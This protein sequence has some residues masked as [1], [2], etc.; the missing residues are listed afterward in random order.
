MAPPPPA[1]GGPRKLNPNSQSFSFLQPDQLECYPISSYHPTPTYPPPP[2]PSMF[3]PPP[4]PPPRGYYQGPWSSATSPAP[5]SSSSSPKP[6]YSPYYPTTPPP[7]PPPPPLRSASSNGGI[8]LPLS[9]NGPHHHHLPPPPPPP[10]SHSPI[11]SPYLAHPLVPRQPSPALQPTPSTSSATT[12]P[13]SRGG[14]AHTTIAHPPPPP[15]PPPAATLGLSHPLQSLAPSAS[16]S[17]SSPSTTPG[18]VRFSAQPSSLPVS[19]ATPLPPLATSNRMSSTEGDDVG[20][21]GSF[22][23]TQH[24]HARFHHG[25][26]GGGGSPATSG[27]EQTLAG[28]STGFG[29]GD[30]GSDKSGGTRYGTS[31]SSPGTTTQRPDVAPTFAASNAPPNSSRRPLDAVDSPAASSSHP[32]PRHPPPPRSSPSH[33]L[34]P[35]LPRQHSSTPA[36]HPVVA[37]PSTPARIRLEKLPPARLF[38]AITLSRKVVVPV[39]FKFP[40]GVTIGWGV[41]KVDKEEEEEEEDRDGETKESRKDAEKEGLGK[42]AVEEEKEEQAESNTAETTPRVDAVPTVRST[43]NT[44]SSAP[45]QGASASVPPPRSD[46][47]PASTSTPISTSTPGPAPAPA[48]APAPA[49]STTTRKPTST[50]PK[51]WADLVRPPPGSTPPASTKGGITP[52]SATLASAPPPP[53][54][55]SELADPASSSSSLSS[56]SP[57]LGSLSALP[58]H[59]HYPGPPVARG[60]INNGNL[61]FANAILQALVY[62]GAF[63]ETLR[64]VER[65]TRADLRTNG[66]KGRTATEAMIAFLAEFRHPSSNLASTAFH[67]SNP[68]PAASSSIPST[69]A[70]SS[71]SSTAVPSSSSS[72]SSS[73]MNPVAPLP[74]TSSSGSS[75]AAATPSTSTTP[76]STSRSHPHLA[77]SSS[78]S[79]LPY[80]SSFS[81]PSSASSSSSLPP[82]SPTPIHDALSSNPRFDAMRRGTQEDAE[83]FLGFFLETLSEEVGEM[84]RKEEE[85]VHK[86]RQGL[87][88]AASTS[89]SNAAAGAGGGPGGVGVNGKG[90]ERELG[91][92]SQDQDGEGWE[93]VGSKG[94]TAVTRTTGE[95]KESPIS[96][97]FGGRLRSVLRCPGQKDS[98]T[99]EPFQRL[100][101]DIQPDHVRTIEDALRNLTSPESLPDFMTSRGHPTSDATKQVTL[102]ELPPVLILHLKRF[103]YDE[104]GGVQKSTKRVG[105]GTQLRI[106]EKVVSPTRRVGVEKG[107]EVARYELFGVVYHHGLQ[108]SGGHYTVAVRTGYHS[109]NWLELDDTQIRSLGPGEIAVNPSSSS[110]S[111]TGP[112]S[113]PISSSSS[114]ASSNL[115]DGSSSS[116]NGGGGGG[117]ATGDRRRRWEATAAMR[118]RE[119]MFGGGDEHKGAYLLLYAKVEE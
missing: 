64:L 30:A 67:P 28:S 47:A 80:P 15:P 10:P 104:V 95:T 87:S 20:G 46:P 39:G 53:S 35:P 76:T 41:P 26:G 69:A 33:P 92:R 89:S 61:C 113:T 62:C 66:Q 107:K 13:P 68:N 94:R 90:K 105:Y 70:S 74:S 55:S 59:Q 96:R 115:V 9:F 110:S 99:I 85:R 93:E 109:P 81:S 31:R 63:W 111:G 119:G 49:P 14:G 43:S 51:S 91:G 97:I 37:P 45:P 6:R 72:P 21:E 71:S 112:A 18:G 16:A 12:T 77:S 29:M 106:E 3:P 75:T 19:P 58:S 65:G 78:S 73:S 114:F 24:P 2:P 118:D 82:L 8:F 102:D 86:V 79:S 48:S 23:A 57:L 101:L 25:G 44:D 34:P 22:F 108:A 11:P 60:L 5:P 4:P 1:G 7:P 42:K 40:E 50:K 32:L 117:G 84:V 54:S 88:A 98:V 100:Q 103:L 83:E 27:I 38:Q 17:S 52:I 116:V 36:S 56:I